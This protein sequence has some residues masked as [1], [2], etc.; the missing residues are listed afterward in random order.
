MRLP[1][2]ANTT[3]LA[4]LALACSL[5]LNAVPA[6]ALSSV[7]VPPAASTLPARVTS[8]EGIT[9]YRLPNGLR[10][11]LAPDAA[12]PVTTVNVTYLVGSRH[13]NYGETGMAHLL[14]HLLFKGTPAYPGDTIPREFARRGMQ[15]N[16]TTA[17]DRTNYF[18]TFAASEDNLDW[19]LRMEADRMVHSFIARS[20][21][22][23]EM[24]VV[25]NELEMGQNNP[26]SVLLQQVVAAA[27][28]WHNYG[29]API[30]ARSDVE[31][32][33]I[34]RLQ[35]F[36]RRYYQPDNAVLVITGK[37]DRDATLERV[38]RYFGAVPRPARA[39][40]AEH[41]VEP[42]QEGPREVTLNRTGDVPAVMAHYH[43]AP[44]AHADTAAMAL[45]ADI[46]T[47]APG[48]RLYRA[49]VESGKASAQGGILRALKDPGSA[50]FVAVAGKDK[51]LAPAREALLA[52]LEG[53]AARP[54]TAD[55]L[56]RARTRLLN[57]YEETLND[58]AA[59]GLALS[60]AIA[61]GDWRLFLIGRDRIAQA[62]LE[63]VQRVALRYLQ[64]ANRTLGQFVPTAQPQRTTIP[65]PLGQAEIAAMVDGYQGKPA[66]APIAAFDP[67]PANIEAGT[68][69][70]TLAN[71]MQLSLLPKPTRGG[72]VSGVLYLRMG[73]TASLQGLDAAGGLTAA[74][75]VR[76]AGAL[77]FRQVADR[78]EA[79][80]AGVSISGDAERVTVRFQTRRAYLPD[81]L[82]LLRDVLRAPQFPA[83]ELE[84]LR[85]RAIAGLEG[86]LTEPGALARNALARH[87][88]PYPAGD[89][90]HTDTLEERIAALRRVRVE[91]LKDFH[92]RFYGSSHAQLAL[93]GDF[94]PAATK[95]QLATLFGDWSA[96][97]PFTRVPRPYLDIAPAAI[98]L[99]T[100]DKASAV[101]VANLPVKL[102][103]EDA[104]YP[105]LL[106]ANRVFGGAS[107]KSRLA[108][109]LRQRDGISY[110]V[111]SMLRIGSLDDAGSFALQAQYAPQNLDKLRRAVDEELAR[112]V[113][114]GITEEE[115]AEA[116]N[117]LLQEAA[118][119]RSDDGALAANLA[120]QR[121]L[122]RTML[123]TAER[124]EKIRQASV[125]AVNAAL[126]AHLDPA[127][128]TQVYAGDFPATAEAPAR[129]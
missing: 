30:G 1:T 100:P 61:K 47:S 32:V 23:S 126:R 70:P 4:A 102:T 21:L 103:T 17:Q 125:A 115:L 60:E 106:I 121:Y 16:G 5:L 111:A 80:K 129:P 104:D 108:D 31:Q 15:F 29:H 68:L 91:D 82:A 101:Y 72:S 105:L 55:E 6:C 51:P 13:E 62:S 50:I 128:L 123:V 25:R 98:V 116:R 94:D 35:A 14:E 38:A 39:L 69:R 78:L 3:P 36:Y 77:D 45:L 75:L 122:G 110:A 37:F 76:G 127:R 43:I 97:A 87:G 19:I 34:E 114:D 85:S 46:L 9:E 93:V 12:Q 53:F 120:N 83:S 71:G 10:I 42:P 109:R 66:A 22:D 88:D 89:P 73:D 49:L 124:E 56:E 41:T 74:M 119:G 67:S 8:V 48:G 99:R 58:P 79:L 92:T 57:A 84:T 117:G 118:V 54:V 27:Y 28:Q 26:N 59:Y 90:R 20:S 33:G 7:P 86:Q 63:D 107:L 96:P 113:K 81:L 11:L 64:P 112:L 44:G 24:T 2:Q 40:P 95:E 65:A 52:E 18:A